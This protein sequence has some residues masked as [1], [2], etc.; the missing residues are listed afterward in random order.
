MPREIK[1]LPP[2]IESSTSADGKHRIEFKDTSHRY[3]WVCECHKGE[4]AV[5]ATTFIKGGYPTGQGID[6]LAEGT[7]AG[8]SVGQT[9]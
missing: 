3:K 1:A 2:E 8:V 5:G 7:G 4:P 9:Q 6:L